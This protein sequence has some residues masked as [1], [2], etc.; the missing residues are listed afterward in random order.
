MACCLHLGFW[1]KQTCLR[2]WTPLIPLT[3]PRPTVRP[4]HQRVPQPNFTF[5]I[6]PPET[7]GLDETILKIPGVDVGSESLASPWT[8]TSGVLPISPTQPYFSDPRH[9]SRPSNHRRAHSDSTIHDISPAKEL[10]NG[11]F[12][13]VITKPG[14]EKRPRTMEDLDPTAPPHLNINIPS[15]RLGTPRF[16]LRGTPLIRGSSYAPTEEIRSSNA[17]MFNRSPRDQNSLFPEFDSTR[18]SPLALPQA[19]FSQSSQ[20]LSPAGSTPRQLRP[21]FTYMSTHAIIEPAMFDDL[22]F[23]PACDDRTTVRYAPNSGAVTAATPPRLVAEI[24]SPTFLDYELISDFFLTYRAFL[25]T[26]YLLRMLIARLRWAVA[27]DD[28]IGMVVRVRTFVAIRHWI[29]NYFI[30][31][32]LVDYGLRV[33]FCNLLNDFV[34]ELSEDARGRKVQLKILAELKKCWRRICALYWDGPEFKDS[35]DVNVAIAPGGIAGHRDANLDP[36]FWDR[37]DLGPPQL[38]SLLA[39]RTYGPEPNSFCADVSKAGHIGDSIVAQRPATPDDQVEHSAD[40]TFGHTSPISQASLDVVSCSFPGLGMRTLNSHPSRRLAAHPV[41]SVSAHNQPGPVATTPKTLVGKRVRPEPP[42]HKRNNSLTESL[43]EHGAERVAVKD[44]E[45]LVSPTYPGSLVRGNFLPPGQAFVDVNPPGRNAELQR[46]TTVFQSESQDILDV[47]AERAAASAM[48]GLGMKKLMYT[49]RRALSTRQPVLS[50]MQGTFVNIQP[51]GPR[52]AT[53]NRLPGTAIVP[54]QPP[55]QSSPRI[56]VRIDLLGAQV[57]ESFKKAVREDAAAEARRRGIP[58]PPM[59]NAAPGFP[60]LDYSAAHMESSTFDTLPQTRKAGVASGTDFTTGSES[61][62]IVDGTMP[63]DSVVLRGSLPTVSPSV[64]TFAETFML[65]SADPTPPNTPP[66]QSEAGVPRRSSYLLNQHVVHQPSP[67][68]S[69]PS[70]L[71]EAASLHRSESHNTRPSEERKRPPLHRTQQTARHPPISGSSHRS[72]KRNKSSRTQ[73]SLNSILHRRHASYSSGMVPPSTARSF[74][75]TTYSEESAQKPDLD[76]P[77]L[78]PSRVLRRRPGGNLRGVNNVGELDTAILRKSRSVGS[79]TTFSDSVQSSFL[80]SAHRGSFGHPVV[81]TSDISQGRPE[82]FSVGKLAETSKKRDVSLFSTYSSRPVMRPSFEVEAQKLAQIPDDADDGGIESALLKLEGKY[83]H[84]AAKLSMD[85]QDQP[86]L[87]EPEDEIDPDSIGLAI[88]SPGAEP[89]GMEAHHYLHLDQPDAVSEIPTIEETRAGDSKA[90]LDVMPRPDVAVRSF[91]SEG[92]HESYSSIPLLE[93]GLT[94]DARSKRTTRA[95]TDRSVLQGSDDEDATPEQIRKRTRQRRLQHLKGD[96]FGSAHKT[97]S[98]EG[99]Q[100]LVT[101]SFTEEQSFLNDDSDHDSELSSELSTE[102]AVSIK[103][104]EAYGFDPVFALPTHP[105]GDPDPAL[106]KIQISP[107]SAKGQDKATSPTEMQI[108]ELYVD[109]LW[110][111]PEP[112]GTEAAPAGPYIHAAGSADDPAGTTEILK[113]IPKPDKEAFRKYS[114]HL[115]FILAFD[116]EVLAQQLTLI[117][118]DAL[119]EIDWKE[120]VDMQWKDRTRANCRSWVDFLR[121]TEDAQGVEV[122]IARFNI[123][124]KW[125]I[126]EIVLTQHIEERARCLIK[127]IH[128]AAH[129]R[130]YRNFATLA[131]LTIALTSND[132]GRLTRTWALVPPRDLRTLQD[133]ETLVTPTRNFYNL[134]AEME[135]GSDGGCIPFVMIYTHDLLYNA[136]RPSEV[137]A[138]PTTAPLVNFER[139]RIAAAVV[140]TLLRLL[141]ASSYYNFQPIEGVTERCL[142]MGALTDAEIRRHSQALE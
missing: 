50:P 2:P 98:T 63:L 64:E 106:S 1:S 79:L 132:V 114:A 101:P 32:F 139:C 87:D 42:A 103:L 82:V 81:A 27:R 35:L 16:T 90:L 28:E 140:K 65:G 105:L 125:A 94:D 62:V 37:E 73:Q 141:E 85:L 109:Q 126:S 49:V 138:S 56:P 57:A 44:Q 21:H 46:Q 130:R 128:I 112:S 102:D 39:L 15:W 11:A 113:S 116:S 53:T 13:I 9:A 137:A 48:S 74:D 80:Y 83:G 25:E 100:G 95:W 33:T 10:D 104:G 14:D 41:S 72:H 19:R 75:A 23:K 43:R 117:E 122:V 89:P 108:P 135:T 111:Q 31:D 121:H 97:S 6:T 91:L 88:G 47:R 20:L 123:M 12:K 69:I 30:D 136:Q 40:P 129:C 18:P 110:T 71:L 66:A 93:R 70:S 86:V 55:R 17:S 58:T 5:P 134:R 119:N 124:V 7:A 76:T 84:Q 127:Y 118:K 52:G 96:S 131:Q 142:W 120:L 68:E 78:Q 59:A 36:S 133:L 67:D 24:T 34:N 77:A 107:H 26:D 61:I 99:A 45:F 29:L 54:Q 3:R 60:Q 92:S 115:P 38:D 22:T 8:P 51:I 4:A